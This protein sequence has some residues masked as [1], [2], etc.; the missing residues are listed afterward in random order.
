MKVLALEHEMPDSS[1]RF[2]PYLHAEA[3]RVWELSQADV[4]RETYF[5]QDR[6]TAVLV[7]ECA[8]EAEARGILDSLPLVQAGLIYFEVIP[9][10]PYPGLE[11][12]FGGRDIA[13]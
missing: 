9:L 10:R 12:L 3:Q 11:R 2:A 8:D 7:L 13:L 6:S 4:V 1:G 5:R